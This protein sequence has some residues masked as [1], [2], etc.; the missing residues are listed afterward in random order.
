VK[1]QVEETGTG[2]SFMD[3]I[4]SLIIDQ[5]KKAAGKTSMILGSMPKSAEEGRRAILYK[6]PY[7]VI[8]GIAPW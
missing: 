8:L 3:W 2:A 4:L 7:E 1:Y 5:L 6:E